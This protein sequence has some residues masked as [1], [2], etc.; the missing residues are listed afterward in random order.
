MINPFKKW[1]PK[2]K[3]YSFRCSQCGDAFISSHN[4][5]APL[6]GTCIQKIKSLDSTVDNDKKCSECGNVGV[7]YGKDRC[8]SCYFNFKK[9]NWLFGLDLIFNMVFINRE[10]NLSNILLEGIFLF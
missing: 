1:K 7:I 2:G 4:L 9:D 6:C 5:D 3:I 10:I 8:H